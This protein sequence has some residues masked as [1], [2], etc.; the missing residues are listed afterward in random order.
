LSSYWSTITYGANQLKKLII[1]FILLFGIGG[2][3]LVA[4]SPSKAVNTSPLTL[5]SGY[6]F[7]QPRG[8]APFSLEDQS[9]A[10]FT[11]ADFAGKWSLVF[12]GYTSCPDV[13]PTTLSKLAA[14]F[15]KLQAVSKVPVQVVFV[16]AD[17]AR[18]TQ[19]KRL[20]YINF[21]NSEFKA[22]TAPHAKLFPFS[23]DLGF[24]YAMVGDGDD[25]QVDHSASYV[26]VSPKGEKFAVFKPKPV[27][28][29]MGQID[30]KELLADL[31][32][33]FNRYSNSEA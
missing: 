9:G 10:E 3:A 15:P 11:Q 27:L 18:D 4:L 17:P 2:A 24:A 8:L 30:H 31:E 14:L 12:V 19:Q 23:R 33:I 20:D 25:Y 22:V 5:S 16:S 26:L 6:L 7:E 1:S 29:Q 13:C 28:G 32:Q 21:F